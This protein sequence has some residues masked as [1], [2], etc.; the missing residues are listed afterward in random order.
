MRPGAI[1][2]LLKGRGPLEPI[3]Q[4]FLLGA[5]ASVA[6]P[7]LMI[8][9]SLAL[10]ARINRPLNVVVGALYT[11][12]IAAIALAPGNWAIYLLQRDRGGA[13][14]NGRLAGLD[15]AQGRSRRDRPVG[16]ATP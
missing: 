13:D 14:R 11:M 6:I 10:T 1:A 7:S 5:S 3:T 8:F 15:L 9:A 12:L 4:M 16:R 2:L